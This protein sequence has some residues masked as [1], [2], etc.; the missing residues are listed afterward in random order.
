MKIDPAL[1]F[2]LLE[3]AR[4]LGAD[5]AEV[6]LKASRNMTA[7]VRGGEVDALQSSVEFGYSLRVIR[8]KR[9]GFSFSNNADDADSVIE[10]SVEA[11]RWTEQDDYLDLPE[12][13]AHQPLKVFDPAIE[14][15]SE[16]EA[17]AKALAV[18]AAA[19]KTDRRIRKVRK[20]SISCSTGDV[21]IANSKG[22]RK[23]YSSS[24]CAAQITVAAEEDG[25]SQM[26]WDFD[27]GRFLGDIDFEAVGRKAA[28]R[29]LC[30]L[31]ARKIEASKAAVVLDDS[32][33]VEF[34][35]IFSSL[36]SSEFVQ[37]GKS[38]LAGKKGE[39]VVS[40]LISVVDD[41]LMERRLGSRPFDGEGVPAFR[42]NLIEEGVLRG[43]MYNIHTARKEGVRSTGNAARP[44]SSSLP[45]VGPSVLYIAAAGS[46][47]SKK[48]LL[49]MPDRCLYVV[50]AMG[51]H[52]ANPVS[53][54]FSIGVSGLWVENGEIKYPVREAVI[55]GN[56]LEFFGRVRA[57][58][59]EPGFY[60]N[61]G[62][63]GLLIEPVDI[64]A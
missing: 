34:L 14:A 7:E 13:D 10:R 39:R 28:D 55:S 50:D 60:G 6:F 11:S 40:P 20:A 18:E 45:S 22:L 59:D 43:Y 17:V 56:I 48:N 31:G 51:I 35:G 3:G 4:A 21:L 63:P 23:E 64:S 12:P 5:L 2:R 44:G 25:K 53:G 1:A 47:T 36:L 16:D 37:K 49:A 58:A 33:A 61:M 15:L 26:G 52:T 41:G 57:V 9:L 62:S 19:L 46:V 29:A 27:G 38:L 30:L 32:V 42:N 54:E 8:D 24:A